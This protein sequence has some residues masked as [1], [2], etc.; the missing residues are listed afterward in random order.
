M[1]LSETAKAKLVD[2]TLTTHLPLT[3]YQPKTPTSR[4][5]VDDDHLCMTLF[6]WLLMVAPSRIFICIYIPYTYLALPPCRC[7][8]A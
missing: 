1:P 5:P 3:S 6:F 7:P 8:S 4:L 2:R